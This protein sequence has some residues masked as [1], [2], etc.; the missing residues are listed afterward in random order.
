MQNT[1]GLPQWYK[2][3]SP[4]YSVTADCVLEWPDENSF[5]EFPVVCPVH[6][7]L[8]RWCLK[9][10][11]KDCT[12]GPPVIKE[13]GNPVDE[14]DRTSRARAR[15]HNTIQ[16]VLQGLW[17]GEEIPC[18]LKGL[19]SGT[20]ADSLTSRRAAFTGEQLSL[21]PRGPVIV[22]SHSLRA[23]TG[24]NR[25]KPHQNIDT[26]PLAH[27][28]E[29]LND[30]GMDSEWCVIF[31]S[32]IRHV[33]P[34]DLNIRYP[35]K[36]ATLYMKIGTRGLLLNVFPDTKC[37]VT[38]INYDDFQLR[39]ELH[40]G[41]EVMEI[42]H[43]V[44]RRYFDDEVYPQRSALKED[45]FQLRLRS[46]PFLKWLRLGMGPCPLVT[47]KSKSRLNPHTLRSHI[48]MGFTI[49]NGCV[50]AVAVNSPAR[51]A[52]LLPDHHIIE[53][54][55]VFVL[56][57]TDQQIIQMIRQKISANPRRFVD[58]VVMPERLHKQLQSVNNPHRIVS[59][60][61]FHLDPWVNAKPFG[62]RYLNHRMSDEELDT[63][64]TGEEQEGEWSRISMPISYIL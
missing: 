19:N 4:L 1:I 8:S 13:S 54:G 34:P 41:D 21:T 35:Y 17:G 25:R 51:E 15:R 16:E 3:V 7:I 45:V 22:N 61:G 47:E 52:G 31:I 62:L 12:C 56:H 9:A 55:G 44:L 36:D 11:T 60:Q 2:N 53:V 38:R 5:N 40:Y 32:Q 39:P 26:L 43:G 27:V 30:L 6:G 28:Y 48:D 18:L 57:H 29:Y 37:F 33:M 46:C 58:V 10:G 63:S 24:C 14:G 49:H 59:N 42:H 20:P 23:R 50:T 64:R